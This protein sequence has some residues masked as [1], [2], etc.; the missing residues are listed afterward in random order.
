MGNSPVDKSRDF[1]KSG[2]TLVTELN[3]D[4]YLEKK[5]ATKP[6][7]K[8]N[9]WLRSWWHSVYWYWTPSFLLAFRM[10]KVKIEIVKHSEYYYW[11]VDYGAGHNIEG[12]AKTL[13]EAMREIM[14]Y[15]NG[16]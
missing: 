6:K 10:P 16:V 15:E 8:V 3:S 9:K 11:L 12:F 13:E 4:K 1:I 2:M 5:G 7:Q 14:Q